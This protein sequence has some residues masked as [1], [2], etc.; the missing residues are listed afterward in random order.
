MTGVETVFLKEHGLEQEGL[1]PAVGASGDG[2]GRGNL[3]HGQAHKEIARRHNHKAPNCSHRAAATVSEG[4]RPCSAA[5]GQRQCRCAGL[6][7]MLEYATQNSMHGYGSGA[8][9][10]PTYI[11]PALSAAENSYN[12]QVF[13]ESC[14]MS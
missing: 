3:C 9:C 13:V 5:Q 7:A 1:S 12:C 2:I 10:C 11:S 14:Q 6:S 8:A 4:Q